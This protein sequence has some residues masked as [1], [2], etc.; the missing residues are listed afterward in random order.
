MYFYILSSD[1]K[2]PWN[3][4]PAFFDILHTTLSNVCVLN[5]RSYVFFE[6]SFDC[7]SFFFF[8]SSNN[9]CVESSSFDK[10]C[11]IRWQVLVFICSSY[12]SLLLPSGS[13]MQLYLLSEKK[14]CILIST[15]TALLFT[16]ASWFLSFDIPDEWYYCGKT[17]KK[18]DL[19]SDTIRN[20]RYTL[21]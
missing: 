10:P 12:F 3:Y 5:V 6:L 14:K 17:V 16:L 4:N 1:V 2:S 18:Q 11:F 20:E 15:A 7:L 13:R 19:F 8:L 21:K 9:P